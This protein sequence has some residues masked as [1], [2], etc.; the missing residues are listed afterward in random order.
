MNPSRL[1]LATVSHLAPINRRYAFF[2][3]HHRDVNA[4]RAPTETLAA[5][6]LLSPTATV[7]LT[8]IHTHAF[9]DKKHCR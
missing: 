2:H 6:V 4:T 7:T 5:P 3:A 9:V 8:R 1:V